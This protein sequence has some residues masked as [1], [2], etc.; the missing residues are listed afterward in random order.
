MGPMPRAGRRRRM[1][2]LLVVL[3]AGVLGATGCGGGPVELPPPRPIIVTSGERLRVD[4][5]RMDSIYAWLTA[6]NTNIEED[7]TFLIEGVPAAR[8]SLPWQTITINARGDTAKVQYDRA[9]PDI[10]T[11]LNVYAHLHLMKR[12]N[13]LAEWLPE[14]VDSEGFALER[15]IVGRM[16]DA[17]LLGRAVFDAPAYGPLDE[18]I[19][20]QEAGYL[21]AYLLTARPQEFAQERQQW[22]SSRPEEPE[23]Y[24][25]W[26][27]RTFNREAPGAQATGQG[28]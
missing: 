17:W 6:E 3:L 12:Q 18:L 11:A 4:P 22:E 7:P 1:F 28:G 26:F 14:H 5:A 16:A 8:E 15:A 9:H 13:R 21:D 2:T 24:R 27:R 19:Y 23:A 20:A 10:L 25:T